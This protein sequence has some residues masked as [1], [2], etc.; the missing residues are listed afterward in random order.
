MVSVRQTANGSET[1]LKGIRTLM[2]A[3]GP[4][5]AMNASMDE[6]LCWLLNLIFIDEM[7]S[8]I[9]T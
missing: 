4:L 7:A 1:G 9:K 8:G 5:R 6:T 3:I 2:F